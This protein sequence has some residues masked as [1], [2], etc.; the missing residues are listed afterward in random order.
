M[1]HLGF[2][3]LVFFTDEMKLW[4]VLYMIDCFSSMG[5]LRPVVLFQDRAVPEIV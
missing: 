5:A 1:V 3:T 2:E 4:H